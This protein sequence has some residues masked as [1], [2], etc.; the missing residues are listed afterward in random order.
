ML[1]VNTQLRSQASNVRLELPQFQGF[2]SNPGGA[3]VAG[4]HRPHAPTARSKI[5]VLALVK[6][7]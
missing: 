3:L 7:H 2:L 1:M 6:I 4:S 5:S